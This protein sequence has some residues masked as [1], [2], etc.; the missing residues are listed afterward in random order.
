VVATALVVCGVQAIANP[1]K[2]IEIRVPEPTPP[3]PPPPPTPQIGPD[4]QPIPTPPPAPAYHPVR[5]GVRREAREVAGVPP[6][7]LYGRYHVVEVTEEG[8]TEDYVI[9][10]RRE[11][12]ALE[13]D[14]ITKRLVF[15]FGP[16]AGE[17]P[18]V[19]QVAEQQECRK[20]GLGVYASELAL[21]LPSTW[22]REPVGPDDDDGKAGKGDKARGWKAADEPRERVKLSLPSVQATASLVRVRK[23]AAGDLHTPS[24]WLGPESKVERRRIEYKVVAEFPPPAPARKRKA[25]EAEPPPPMA[26]AVHLLHAGVVWHLEPE[27]ADGP[28]VK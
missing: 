12:R 14:C 28:F 3:P 10:M 7:Y 24:H 21:A 8:E 1:P 5:E 15:D 20:G 2:V 22:A 23:P 27:P 4:G 17:L 9:K 18:T 6:T 26:L 13:Q 16:A 11:G 25:E 19:L